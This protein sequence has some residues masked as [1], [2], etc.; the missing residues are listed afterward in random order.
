LWK[1]FWRDIG[2][3]IKT[4]AVSPIRHQLPP[5]LEGALLAVG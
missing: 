3:A 5:E 1:K 2:A 4:L